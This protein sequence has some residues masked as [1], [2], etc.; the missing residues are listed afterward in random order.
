MNEQ[1]IMSAGS[2]A[3]YQEKV[4]TF[5]RTFSLHRNDRGTLSGLSTPGPY[6]STE[7]L[8]LYRAILRAARTV[9]N[10]IVGI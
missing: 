1:D 2:R 6:A 10:G 5:T 9:D 4:P 3:M 7:E 8:L